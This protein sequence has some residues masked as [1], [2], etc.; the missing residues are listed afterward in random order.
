MIIGCD[1]SQTL[2]LH[3][4]ITTA[5]MICLRIWKPTAPQYHTECNQMEMEEQFN[6]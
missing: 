6:I 3:N 4:P 1:P 2:V 5:C